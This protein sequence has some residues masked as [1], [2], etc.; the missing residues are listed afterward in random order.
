MQ[1][2]DNLVNYN[3]SNSDSANYA[4]E[5]TSSSPE[6]LAELLENGVLIKYDVPLLLRAIKPDLAK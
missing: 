1:L 2:S 5:I 3:L 4:A 6:S